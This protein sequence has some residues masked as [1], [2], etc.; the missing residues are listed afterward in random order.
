[1]DILER[2]R[3]DAAEHLIIAKCWDMCPEDTE[4]WRHHKTCLD[5]AKEIGSLRSMVDDLM[6]ELVI[7]RR[8]MIPNEEKLG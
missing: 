1:M 2:L 4:N 5:A 8:S 3:N 7:E 6:R